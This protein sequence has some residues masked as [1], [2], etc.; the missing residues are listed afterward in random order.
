MMM[1]NFNKRLTSGFIF[2]V[3]VF[4]AVLIAC[5]DSSVSA[6]SNT[7]Q[8]STTP[9]GIAPQ[10]PAATPS[11]PAPKGFSGE[12]AFN[13]VARLVG[14]G[15][16]PPASDAIRQT[17]DATDRGLNVNIETPLAPAFVSVAL[18]SAYFRS[19]RSGDAEREYKAALD[20]DPKAGEAH[21]NLA[22]V[23]MLTG[24]F[25]DA[26]KEAALAEKSGFE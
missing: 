22:V 24:R 12:L 3:I 18:G 23:Y 15:P 4:C 5:K 14:F 2:G 11:G 9:T 20:A 19:E 8:P 21:N 1:T 26:T 13:Q 10:Q 25:E 16:R 17:Q 6:T 7:P